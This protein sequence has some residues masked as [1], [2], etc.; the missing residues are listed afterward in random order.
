MIKSIRKLM[1]H[2]ALNLRDDIDRLYVSRKEGRGLTSIED[3]M[4]ALLWSLEEC[5]KNEQR[6]T[7]QSDQNNI[8]NTMINSITIA[9]K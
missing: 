1:T 4:N 5:I 2:K 7:N 3:G 8:D 6:K 9:W